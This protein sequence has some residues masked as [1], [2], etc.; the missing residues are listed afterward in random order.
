MRSSSAGSGP[1]SRVRDSRRFPFTADLAGGR[2]G[3]HGQPGQRRRRRHQVQHEAEQRQ[4][5]DHRPGRAAA[6]PSPAPAVPD[7][8]Y[9]P[10]PLA[11]ASRRSRRRHR[12]SAPRRR[13]K[14]PSVHRAVR[15]V[16]ARLL[17]HSASD[18]D[19]RPP[20]ATPLL[21]GNALDPTPLGKR[22][23][24]ETLRSVFPGFRASSSQHPPGRAELPGR[25]CYRARFSR[26]LPEMVSFSVA[27]FLPKGIYLH[28]NSE[29]PDQPP[30]TTLVQCGTNSNKF[31][32]M[33]SKSL[34]CC[35]SNLK[36]QAKFDFLPYKL[37]EWDSYR[38]N[39]TS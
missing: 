15:R 34:M 27:L 16:T 39:F 22:R 13:L 5:E 37:V 35:G 9:R 2:G 1:S 33:Q 18:S 26:L 30:T 31:P 14:Y 3:P 24:T 8:R 10:P 11:S 19:K 29:K 32:I 17:R 28:S 36:L 4:A 7:A 23:L 12:G 25:G 20:R 21:P 38:P 6:A